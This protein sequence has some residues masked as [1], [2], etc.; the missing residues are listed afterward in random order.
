MDFLKYF[1]YEYKANESNCWEFVRYVCAEEDGIYLP[2]LPIM[3]DEQS[4]CMSYLKANIQ[5]KVVKEA[6]KGCLVHV[7]GEGNEHIGYAINSKEYMHLKN[8]GVQVSKIPQRCLIYEG[9]K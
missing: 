9:V 2:E 6:K 7:W 3:D 8:I 1:N 5:H 4:K